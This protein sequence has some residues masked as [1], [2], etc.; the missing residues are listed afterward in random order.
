MPNG[1]TH[2]LLFFL[3]HLDISLILVLGVCSGLSGRV[4]IVYLFSLCIVSL[5]PS[6]VTVSVLVWFSNFLKYV[7][8]IRQTVRDLCR[9]IE[10]AGYKLT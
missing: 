3:L 1:V 8:L 4:R 6:R 9:S 5:L 7:Y 10:G 2:I